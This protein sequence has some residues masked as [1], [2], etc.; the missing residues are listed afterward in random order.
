MNSW[1]SIT[2]PSSS[3]AEIWNIEMRYYVTKNNIFTKDPYKKNEERAIQ[4][5]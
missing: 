2:A 3:G 5:Q 4:V 1:L